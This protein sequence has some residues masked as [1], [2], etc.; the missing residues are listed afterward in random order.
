M[1]IPNYAPKN[2][3]VSISIDAI[4][5]MNM[6]G[7]VGKRY[8]ALGESFGLQIDAGFIPEKGIEDLLQ[9]IE[10][11]NKTIFTRDDLVI[12]HGD[13]AN[14]DEPFRG[15]KQSLRLAEASPSRIIVTY[16]LGDYTKFASLLP[17]NIRDLPFGPEHQISFLDCRRHL[18]LIS[19]DIP[20]LK[21]YFEALIAL[22]G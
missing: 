1:F 14:P 9:R 5:E 4:E 15:I 10:G 20:P 19:P 2:L 12:L 22:R 16:D 17:E 8:H 7:E 6:S 13:M 18:C 11:G 21:R 3:V